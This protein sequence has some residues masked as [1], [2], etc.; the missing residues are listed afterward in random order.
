LIFGAQIPLCIC[1]RTEFVEILWGFQHFMG[2]SGEYLNIADVAKQ[3]IVSG[4]GHF[5]FQW[6]FL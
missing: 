2:V 5:T 6:S 4:Q 3:P 1:L